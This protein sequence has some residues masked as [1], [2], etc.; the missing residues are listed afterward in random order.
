MSRIDPNEL[1]FPPEPEV[2][3][4]WKKVFPHIAQYFS[5]PEWPKADPN[6][7]ENTDISMIDGED[8]GM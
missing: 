5:Y 2:Q 4:L 7:R 3:E 1:R 6:P 8:R